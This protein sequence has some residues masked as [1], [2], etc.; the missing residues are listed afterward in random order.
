MRDAVASIR[1][2]RALCRL[3]R[4]DDIDLAAENAGSLL[5]HLH[6]LVQTE[7]APLVIEEQIDVGILFGLAARR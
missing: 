2:R 4:V 3:S 1:W 5:L 7:P 6:Q